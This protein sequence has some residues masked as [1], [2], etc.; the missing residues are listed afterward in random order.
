[1]L[2]IYFIFYF[3]KHASYIL[4]KYSDFVKSEFIKFF[5]FCLDIGYNI[6]MGILDNFE[7]SLDLDPIVID[8]EENKEKF[9]QDLGRPENDGLALKMFQEG[10]CDNCN[11]KN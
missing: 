8:D 7:N 4:E 10:C 3:L 6:H 2:T 9:W 5:R 11:C 1:M